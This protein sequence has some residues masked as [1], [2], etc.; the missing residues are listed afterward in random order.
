MSDIISRPAPSDPPLRASMD[1]L[2]PEQR[3]KLGELTQVTNGGHPE[4]ELAV[5]ES[6]GW[7]VAVRPRAA[8]PARPLT[9][10]RPA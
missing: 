4:H 6:V 1:N 10:C 5:L 3:D 8:L 2:T 9:S 7:D